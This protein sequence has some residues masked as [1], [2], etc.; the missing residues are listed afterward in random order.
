M[1]AALKEPNTEPKNFTLIFEVNCLGLHLYECLMPFLS[2]VSIPMLMIQTIVTYV[3]FQILIHPDTSDVLKLQRHSEVPEKDEDWPT[4]GSILVFRDQVRARLLKLYDDFQ[5]GKRTINRHI[6][7]MLAMTHEHEGWHVEVS[8]TVCNDAS[9]V[10]VSVRHCCTC[11]FKEL[12]RTRS[13]PLDLPFLPGRLSR[14]N[15]TR[16]SLLLRQPSQLVLQR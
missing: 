8:N 2:E 14:T 13:L 3:F 5:T 9:E 4:L 11:S 7:R 10:D 12:E 15:G 1:S 16:F 6:A